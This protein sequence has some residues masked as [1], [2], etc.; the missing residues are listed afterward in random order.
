[1]NIPKTVYE[2]EDFTLSTFNLIYGL[3]LISGPL[4]TRYYHNSSTIKIQEAQSFSSYKDFQNKQKKP[5]WSVLLNAEKIPDTKNKVPLTFSAGTLGFSQTVSFLK[6]PSFYS[7]PGPYG[8]FLAIDS[9]LGIQQAQK[10]AGEKPVSMAISYKS[11][12]LIIQTAF[13]ETADFLASTTVKL[14]PS[15]YSKLAINAGFGSF[16]LFPKTHDGYKTTSPAFIPSKQYS[17]CLELFSSVPLFQTKL[18]AGFVSNPFNTIRF[19]ATF[20]FFFHY[21]FFNLSGGFFSADTAFIKNGEPFY[22]MSGAQEKTLYQIKLNPSAIFYPGE[23][24]TLKSGITALYDY[25]LNET[26]YNRQATQKLFLSAG[27]WVKFSENSISFLYKM[28]N[29]VL[30]EFSGPEAHLFTPF[31]ATG[32]ET[33]NTGHSFLLSY[34]HYFEKMTLSLYAKEEFNSQN[35]IIKNE[36]SENFTISAAFKDFPVTNSSF[37]ASLDHKNQT[38]TPKFTL[39]MT[40]SPRLKNVKFTGKFQVCSTLLVE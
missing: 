8:T 14:M 9:G 2:K 15:P 21:N 33:Q 13:T 31:E 26:G 34:S 22:T 23:K 28:N 24:V 3:K 39:G 35:L 18:C 12:D 30:G 36:H 16:S 20:E 5:A 40:V 19:F 38:V 6:N 17:G 1:M 27:T 32:A 25:S 37:S 29:L 7:S 4:E 11:K 10:T